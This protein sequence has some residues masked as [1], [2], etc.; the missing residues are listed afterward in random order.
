MPA[1]PEV[2]AIVAGMVGVHEMGRY[3]APGN[4]LPG[5]SS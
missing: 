1:V 3:L 5:M 2:G 4:R